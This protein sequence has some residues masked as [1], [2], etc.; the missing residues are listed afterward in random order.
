M[1]EVRPHEASVVEV[2]AL[3]GADLEAGLTASAALARLAE[4]GSNELG[5][6]AADSGWQRFAAQF[7]D[8]LVILLLIAAGI[9]AV[10]WATEGAAAL[11][12][13][14]IVIVA[15]VVLNALMGFVQEGRAEAALAAL[16]ASAAPEA[17]VV[18]DGREQRIPAR[19]LVPGD[20]MILREGDT[21][22][23]DARLVQV[24]ELQTMEASLT[25]E[26][27]PV[28]KSV[29][30][31]LSASAVAE[32]V[33]TVFAGTAA[34]YGHARAIVTATG[35]KTEVGSIA[36]LLRST[37]EQI[38]PLQRDLT[39]IGKQLGL[40]VIVIAGIVV[41]TL[42]MLHGV[43]DL[44]GLVRVLMFGVALAVAAAPE[45][46]SAVV[47]MVLALGVQKMARCGAIVRK[48]SAV[49]SLGS[50]T[51]IASDKTGTLTK[52]EMTVQLI[53]TA[54]ASVELTGAGYSPD[55]DLRMED[56]VRTD[57][58]WKH[59][60]DRLLHAATLANN[61]QLSRATGAWTVQGDPTE[62]ALLVAAAKAGIDHTT[63]RV[64]YPRLAEAPFS[65][66]RKR[67]STLHHA[68]SAPGDQYVFTK[69]AAGALLELCTHELVGH[70]NRELT[71]ERRAAI[72]ADNEA[73]ASE[74]L[75]TL[76]VAFR[77][78]EAPSPLGEAADPKA[79]ERDLVFLGLIGMVDPP[80][81]E[82][83]KSVARARAAGIR[84]MLITGDH[85]AT[86][87]A[88]ARETGVS[89][90]GRVLCGPELETMS[91][92]ELEEAVREVSVFARVVPR[93]KLRIVTALQRGGEIVAMTGDGVNDA[94]ALKAADIGIAMG[95]TGTD[96]A[97]EASDLVLTDD[98]FATIVVA[99][100]EGRAVFDNIR[101]TIRY[102][103][104]TNAGE[105]MTVFFAV[106]LAR[107]LGL[108]PEDGFVL[109]L[110][111]T[112][113]LWINLITDGAPSLA[114]GIDPALP[115]LMERSPR[116]RKEGVINRPM[117]AGILLVG[118]VMT[119]GTLLVFHASLPGG[120]P[121][122]RT[123]AFS[124]L[125]FVQLFHAFNSRS[126]TDSVFRG[127]FANRWLC[128][129]VVISLLLHAMLLQ[130]P[131]LQVAFGTVGLSL[132]EWG[133]CLG[134]A[135]SVLW[136][137]EGAKLIARTAQRGVLSASGRA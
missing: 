115:N 60:T 133:E 132:A 4:F 113:I 28:L 56:A 14:T 31:V 74:A 40:A 118:L 135:S 41:A 52:N 39:R 107:P 116:S 136:I 70:E 42:L 36:G 129:A 6:A 9:S 65:S 34:T 91:D 5:A 24:V 106:I 87:V 66:D 86:A 46:L 45:S 23:A 58:R 13:E 131:G 59:E 108:A 44:A 109:P 25:G 7:R 97:K 95:I 54:N 90:D 80:R 72:L 130:V 79:L 51:V 49:E 120:I 2:A 15:I 30:P 123:M 16:R 104:S 81:P 76:G 111:A 73:M 26:S 32:R 50:V 8:A 3:F 101:K 99:V 78:L 105:V 22:A 53:V 17:T 114:L 110:L 11:P 102:L 77:R 117:L 127:F 119:V 37:K 124:T 82:A 67:M 10:V 35:M 55:G 27:L 68:D 84:P 57:G 33:N 64:R 112:Q 38:T 134:V 96:V 121:Y 125:V 103:L 100:E 62:G 89:I 47:T 20:L 85:P 48:L 29:E 69:G 63:L 83:G 126:E 94:P 61:A 18:R 128:G 12:Y 43:R 122:A 93:H 92:A 88:I 1:P 137:V 19:D 71:D 75:R 21:I 98:N